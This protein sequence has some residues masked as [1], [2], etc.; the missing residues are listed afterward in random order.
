[1]RTQQERAG[2]LLRW[3]PKATP[4]RA[5]AGLRTRAKEL[6][7]LSVVIVLGTLLLGTLFYRSHYHTW[8][9]QGPRGRV[10]WCGRDY[11][12]DRSAPAVS[13]RQIQATYDASYRFVGHYPPLGLTKSQVVAR[14]CG[15]VVPTVI[16]LSVGADQY[17]SYGLSGGP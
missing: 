3:H 17:V 15:P 16:F 12:G 1:V 14:G 11:N 13:L 6:A 2:R 10:T 7:P 4:A 5:R 9:G 8:P